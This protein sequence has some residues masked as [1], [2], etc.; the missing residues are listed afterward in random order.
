[1]EDAHDELDTIDGSHHDQLLDESKV[2][3]FYIKASG[4][5][6]HALYDVANSGMKRMNKLRISRPLGLPL[7]G[8]QHHQDFDHIVIV[9]EGIGI[10]PWLSLL[11]LA[12][13]RVHID[14]IW[15]IRKIDTYYA[16][17]SELTH[18]I[19]LLQDRLA[20]QIYLTGADPESNTIE[21]SDAIQFY[22]MRPDYRLVLKQL[23]TQGHT[24]LAVCA[25]EDTTVLTSNIALENAWTVHTE[26]FE[27]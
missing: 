14:I 18:F 23:E 5:Q 15:S 7:L 12:N 10:T 19:S 2:F 20:I 1:M 4:K 6:T 11:E 13:H 21:A 22:S 24:L 16:F 27:L 3:T 9:S 26:R 25:H 17:E 8:Y